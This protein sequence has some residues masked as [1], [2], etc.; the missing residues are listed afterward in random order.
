MSV[1]VLDPAVLDERGKAARVARWDFTAAETASLF[2]RTDSSRAI[3]L[4]MAWPADPPKHNKLHLFVRYVTADGRKL[5]ADRP[6]EVALPGERQAGWTPAPPSARAAD[7]GE[8]RP[9]ARQAPIGPDA[10][11]WRPNETP[12]AAC[13]RTSA[14]D[15]HPHRSAQARAARPGR[16]SGDRMSRQSPDSCLSIPDDIRLSIRRR[17]TQPVATS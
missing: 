8:F 10:E 13:R 17:F 16:P 2:R 1:V 14:R 15:G 3:H 5:E 7:G 4:A 9:P 6:I 11:S 12:S